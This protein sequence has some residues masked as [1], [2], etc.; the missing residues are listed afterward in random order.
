M[1]DFFNV[2]AG[3]DGLG[4]FAEGTEAIG[5]GAGLVGEIPGSQQKRGDPGIFGEARFD[6]VVK[7]PGFGTSDENHGKG[8]IVCIDQR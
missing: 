1:E 3:G 4:N 5:L 6:F 8:D 2:R 7:V